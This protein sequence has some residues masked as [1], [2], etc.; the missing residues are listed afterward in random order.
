MAYSPGGVDMK[1]FFS[2]VALVLVWVVSSPAAVVYLKDGGQ[3]KA[4]RAWRENGKVV[5][6]VNHESIAS[7]ASSEVNLGKTFP[8]RKKRVRPAKT[9]LPAAAV[10]ET[11]A[12]EAK[13]APVQPSKVGKQFALPAL[14]GKLPARQI[15]ASSEEGT[16]RKQK[17]ELEERMRD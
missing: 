9:T 10:T 13:A 14:S 16:L 4:K 3:I 2:S 12:T 5:V 17:R 11:P 7:F 6:L 8:A 1:T 15:P